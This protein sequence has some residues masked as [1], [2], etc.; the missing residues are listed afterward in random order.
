MHGIQEAFQDPLGGLVAMCLD[1]AERVLDP[2]G[3][4]VGSHAL[5][6]AIREEDQKVAAFEKEWQAYEAKLLDRYR[7][8]EWDEFLGRCTEDPDRFYVEYTVPG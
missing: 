7:K 2:E 8:P 6:D 5:Q 1:Q 4:P 3:I